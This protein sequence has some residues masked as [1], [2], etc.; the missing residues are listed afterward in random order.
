VQQT[1]KEKLE[2]GQIQS[3]LAVMLQE[4]KQIPDE[5]QNNPKVQQIHKLI[6]ANIDLESKVTK[7]FTALSL[8]V[9]A[10]QEHDKQTRARF[11]SV[12]LELTQIQ[13]KEFR[14]MQDIRLLESAITEKQV[15]RNPILNQL[16]AIEQENSSLK[17]HLDKLSKHYQ[18]A[19]GKVIQR[20]TSQNV[21]GS[22]R[23]SPVFSAVH[24]S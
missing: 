14:Q 3:D 24:N 1:K 15:E 9:Q 20:C 21:F 17:Q 7:M 18:N 4:Y 16:H 6:H 13:K 5:E 22:K 8:K 19:F 10:Q 11:N 2:L 23:P 12:M